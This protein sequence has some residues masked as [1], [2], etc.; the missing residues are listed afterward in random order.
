MIKARK[1]E[2]RGRTLLDWLDS[3]HTFSFGDYYEPD[4]S[5]LRSLRVINEDR[6]QPGQGFPSHSH[7]D[8][9][10]V[11]YVL[12]GELEHKDSLGNGSVIHPGE[13]QRMSAGRGITHSEFNHSRSAPVHFLQIWI[14]PDEP[15]LAPS[16]EQEAI[17]LS[18][19][20]GRFRAI[21]TPAGGTRMVRLHQNA[22][23]SLAIMEPG[24]A[25]AHKL[26]S[27]YAWLQ[28]ATGAIAFN[29]ETMRAGD[30]A[31]IYDEPEIELEAAS[32]AEIL[33]FE[34]S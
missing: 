12:D 11:T 23:I 21:A 24:E 28:I 31:A 5:G 15:G 14:L 17:D 27:R 13:I 26:P 7:R 1:A 2:E 25:L 19:A 10:I 32:A 18:G 34:L 4:Q 8:M 33:M 9:E 6:V 22:A 30:G 16:Y 29:G 20:R 3:R